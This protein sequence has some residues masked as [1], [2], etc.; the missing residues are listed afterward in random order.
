MNADDVILLVLSR[1]RASLSLPVEFKGETDTVDVPGVVV[2]AEG[3]RRLANRHGASTYAGPVLDNMGNEI[4]EEHHI[5]QALDLDVV[6]QT[7]DRGERADVMEAIGAAFYPYESDVVSLDPDVH[8]LTVG[9]AT[10]RDLMLR[11][12]AQYVYGRVL[13]FEYLQRFTKDGDT[14]TSIPYWVERA[15]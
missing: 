6:V 2:S 12:P 11:E 8:S 9:D 5:Y 1:L 7:N 10:S 13:G 14:L 3:P 15:D 4:S